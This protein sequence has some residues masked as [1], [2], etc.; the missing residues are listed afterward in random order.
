MMG[1]E[2]EAG[3]FNAGGGQ[4]SAALAEFLVELLVLLVLF[5]S[6]HRAPT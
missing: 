6:I 5:V 3:Y 4:L 2:R 1:V